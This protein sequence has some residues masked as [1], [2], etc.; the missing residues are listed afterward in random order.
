[1]QSVQPRIEALLAAPAGRAFLLIAARSG[2]DP[3]IIAEPQTSMEIA[4]LALDAVSL[5]RMDRA[6][7]LGELEG[8]DG[9]ALEDLARVLLACPGAAWWFAPLERSHQVWLSKDAHPPLAA[10]LVS[11]GAPPSS[12][13]RYAQ[14]PAGG[15]FTS[16]LIDGSSS[17]WTVIAL[18]ASDLA[19][20]FTS[21]PI[22]C[23]RL[24]ARSD[25]RILEIDGP[26]AW[27]SLCLKYAAHGEDGRTVPDWSAVARDYDAVHLTLGGLLTA[28]QVRIVS[29]VGCSEHWGWDVE[30]TLWLHW[31]FTR[32]ERLPDRPRRPE[33]SPASHA[34][35]LRG[36]TLGTAQSA[37]DR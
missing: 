7:M 34:G 22:A 20:A 2:L 32:I 8:A 16:T 26:Q 3:A 24:A 29:S 28:E 37:K 10:H 33:A 5:W 19:D 11:P 4:A 14:K 1:M 25:A 6:A 36:L 12:W 13:E 31:S 30:Q 9:R 21:D 35:R 23:W 18:G 27:H 15:F 17:A